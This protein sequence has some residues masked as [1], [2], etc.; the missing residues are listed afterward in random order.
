MY[1]S[2]FRQ[3][4]F[5]FHILFGTSSSSIVINII[6]SVLETTITTV[7]ANTTQPQNIPS[8]LY[9]FSRSHSRVSSF[10]SIGHFQ[11]N[12]LVNHQLHGVRLPQVLEFLVLEALVQAVARNVLAPLLVVTLVDMSASHF[13]SLEGGLRANY[14]I[15]VSPFFRCFLPDFIPNQFLWQSSA[16]VE[17]VHT[18]E[19]V[20]QLPRQRIAGKSSWDGLPIFAWCE[21]G[22]AM[23]IGRAGAPASGVG[24]KITKGLSLLLGKPGK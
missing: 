4:H 5:Y 14:G 7:G 15:Q 10:S 21:H 3:S 17:V 24:D 22:F 23:L 18:R 8:G 19:R 2:S 12:P 9:G 6:R 13:A 1:L 20:E 11:R 16:R